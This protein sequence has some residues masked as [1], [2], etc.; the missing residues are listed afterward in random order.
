MLMRVNAGASWIGKRPG[1]LL[2]QP[3]S[4]DGDV[5]IDAGV[6]EPRA[7]GTRHLGM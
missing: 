6:A 7:V 3:P 2:V 5:D 4:L 1:I